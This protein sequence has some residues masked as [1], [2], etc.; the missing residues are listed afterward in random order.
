MEGGKK[1]DNLLLAKG[2]Q[3][4]IAAL[5]FVC[6]RKGGCCRNWAAR[7]GGGGEGKGVLKI[8]KP[9]PIPTW[10]ARPYLGHQRLGVVAAPL[11]S[12]HM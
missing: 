8:A 5:L 6:E 7:G 1:G 3:F 10:G 12:P 2:R 4:L 9:I 11:T